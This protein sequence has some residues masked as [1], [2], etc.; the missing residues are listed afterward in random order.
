MG[1]PGGS[2]GKESVR[3]AGDLSSVPGS[4]RSSGEGN[5]NLFQY[6]CL[7]N[8]TDGGV[9]WA[10]AHRVAKSQTRLSDFIYS[11][12]H[13]HIYANA[14]FNIHYTL[15]QHTQPPSDGHYQSLLDQSLGL[16]AKFFHC[17]PHPSNNLSAFH[18]LKKNWKSIFT[19]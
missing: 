19:I 12:T 1:F 10:T 11:L 4:A 5:G 13:S 7:E 6:S 8:P 16:L 17:S 18:S 14:C 2:D 15:I 3:S 9:W